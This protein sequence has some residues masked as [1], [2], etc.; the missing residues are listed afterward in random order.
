MIPSRT[1]L[2][3]FISPLSTIFIPVF[4]VLKIRLPTVPGTAGF[5]IQIQWEKGSLSDALPR[6]RKLLSLKFQQT[7]PHLL[8]VW[9]W[10]IDLAWSLLSSD[11][12]SVRHRHS[13][14]PHHCPSLFR[15]PFS[16]HLPSDLPEPPAAYPGAASPPISQAPPGLDR[17][18][19][20]FLLNTPQL[21]WH[22]FGQ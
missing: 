4:S 9:F 5:L 17:G 20:H 10:L 3:H 2:H 19:P 7:M 12:L 1:C 11:P 8:W 22:P 18:A 15:L 21:L 14:L 6:T 16:H 13:L